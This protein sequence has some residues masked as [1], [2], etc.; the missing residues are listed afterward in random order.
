M[1]VIKLLLIF[2]LISTSTLSSVDGQITGDFSIKENLIKISKIDAEYTYSVDYSIHEVPIFSKDKDIDPFGR[3]IL[4]LSLIQSFKPFKDIER[5]YPYDFRYL[6]KVKKI[7]STSNHPNLDVHIGKE[8][9]IDYY[10]FEDKIKL[11]GL[12][13]Y[14]NSELTRVVK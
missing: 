7:V 12:G 2:I 10:K 9:Y 4:E 14:L 13:S 3:I 8:I 11:I 6:F 5:P 1:K